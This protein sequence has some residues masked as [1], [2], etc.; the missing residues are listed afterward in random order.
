MKGVRRWCSARTR[1]RV[2]QR[3]DSHFRLALRYPASAPAVAVAGINGGR[4]RDDT[5]SD[6]I[7]CK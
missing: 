6:R 7:T 3:I 4:R 1:V 5:R 2:Y